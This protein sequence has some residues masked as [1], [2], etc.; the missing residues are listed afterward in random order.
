[1][2]RGLPK[3]GVLAVESIAMGVDHFS[4]SQGAKRSETEHLVR[5]F[6]DKTLML[7]G[8]RVSASR[9]KQQNLKDRA[10]AKSAFESASSKIQAKTNCKDC[11]SFLFISVRACRV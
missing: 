7:S 9:V 8:H 3:L 5:S 11:F 1:M 4:L 10:D 6:E 2:Q